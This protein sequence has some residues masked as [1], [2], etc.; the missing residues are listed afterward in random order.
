MSLTRSFTV[1]LLTFSVFGVL[2]AGCSSEDDSG[3]GTAVAP[4][5]AG[6]APAAADTAV[7]ADTPV[8]VDTEVPAAVV[9]TYALAQQFELSINV[10]S[11]KFNRI[12]RIPR[13]YS[14]TE[15][16]ISPPISW[17]EPP[18]GTVSLALVVDSN[19]HPGGLWAHWVLWG[20][21]PDSRGLPESVANA[22]DAP[23]IGPNARQGTNSE[24]EVGWSGPCPPPINLASDARGTPKDRIVSEYFFKLYA[25][26]T[27]VGLGSDATMED[28][29]RAIDGHILAGG[30]LT[31]EHV[32]DTKIIPR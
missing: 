30:E 8:P 29:L 10:T 19:Q 20:I 21:P 5:P 12:R 4:A 6:G 11:T 17:S 28:L 18:E 9:E 1:A 26:D 25:L 24:E 23:S 27:D 13:K 32:S 22:P 2:L 14:C 15:E 31:G 16:D 7:P 3:T